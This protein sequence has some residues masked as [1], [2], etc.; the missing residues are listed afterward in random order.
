MINNTYISSEGDRGMW[1]KRAVKTKRY[2]NSQCFLVH[3]RHVY[4]IIVLHET[5][6]YLYGVWCHCQTPPDWSTPQKAELRR[7]VLT[8]HYAWVGGRGG[9]KAF[10][11]SERFQE[12][13]GSEADPITLLTTKNNFQKTPRF[14]LSFFNSV[15]WDSHSQAWI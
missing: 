5:N 1:K 4:L 15:L 2:I 6:V 9:R 7:A 3:A 8:T 13:Q 11:N 14:V 12:E 10:K